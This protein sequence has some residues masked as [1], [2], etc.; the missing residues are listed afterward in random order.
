MAKHLW[1]IFFP[2]G[3][4]SSQLEN[5]AAL[6]QSLCILT[7]TGSA[8]VFYFKILRNNCKTAMFFPVGLGD[9]VDHVGDS[10]IKNLLLAREDS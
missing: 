2:G 7:D 4:S 9:M 10:S 6:L 8:Y 1:C 5:L 3:P